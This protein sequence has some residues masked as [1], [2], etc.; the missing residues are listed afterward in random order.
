MANLLSKFRLDYSSLQM[1]QISDKPKEKTQ[2]FFD[3][4]IEDF[5]IKND[6][7]SN[8]MYIIFNTVC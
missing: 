8:G 2:E 7:E 5:K 6:K 3:S 4:I 1:V